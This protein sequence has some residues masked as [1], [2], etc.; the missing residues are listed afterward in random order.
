MTRDPQRRPT[1]PWCDSGQQRI[2]LSANRAHLA[3]T[4]G[5]SSRLFANYLT[6]TANPPYQFEE[7]SNEETENSL[8]SIRVKCFVFASPCFDSLP[9]YLE[10][11]T[12]DRQIFCRRICQRTHVS[13]WYDSLLIYQRKFFL[14]AYWI[15]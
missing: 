7:N 9:T 15:Y 10:V 8:P 13:G 4:M 3:E 11:K 6:S 14:I 1:Q 5:R 2:Y 12:K